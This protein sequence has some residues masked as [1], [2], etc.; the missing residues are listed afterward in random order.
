MNG[1]HPTSCFSDPA[2]A[3]FGKTFTYCLISIVSLA[4]NT[5]IG[6]IVYRTKAMKKSTNFLLVNMAMSDLLLPIFLFPRIITGFY[7]DSWLVG[8]SLGHALCTLHMFF[9]NVSTSVSIQSLV[10]IA[11]DRFGAVVLP[12]RSPLIGPKLCLVFISFTWLISMAIQSPYFFAF[13]LVEYSGTLKCA[14]Q[15]TA[16]FGD[17]SSFFNY[18]LAIFVIF[19]CIPLV[20]MTVLYSII[21][22]KLKSQPTPGEH[23][24]NAARQREKRE[25]NMLKMVIA[26]V[27]SFAVCWV[28]FTI[29]T[30]LGKVSCDTIHFY[31]IARLLASANCAINPCIC[32]I[33]S[34]N[35]RRG[36]KS[37]IIKCSCCVAQ[38]TSNQ[39]APNGP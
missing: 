11:V 33:F 6:L 3:T 36:L 15:W 28:P 26:I 7:V 31:G 34:R 18:M 17:S 27:L 14:L 24:S 32:L 4:G 19:F 5:V 8:G 23:S 21:V 35:Y 13:R 29:F 25:R 22:F 37:L 9:S 38:Q 2:A 1:T 16:A 12:F 30:L 39:V 10:L 20:L